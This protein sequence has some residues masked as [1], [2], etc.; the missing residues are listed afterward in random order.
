MID[1]TFSKDI[2]IFYCI[3][4]IKNLYRTFL[5][6]KF[7]IHCLNN[8]AFGS[9]RGFRKWLFGPKIRAKSVS[10]MQKKLP[11]LLLTTVANIEVRPLLIVL[12]SIYSLHALNLH[13]RVDKRIDHC[14]TWHLD[15]HCTKG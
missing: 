1:T 10:E 13:N 6:T 8:F 15:A 7:A 4:L 5:A 14:G 9:G 11:Q 12:C 2:T 3:L